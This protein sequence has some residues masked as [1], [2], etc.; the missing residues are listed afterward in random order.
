MTE[1]RR[2]LFRVAGRTL[3]VLGAAGY[4][5]AIVT[6]GYRTVPSLES[7]RH[8]LRPQW[9]TYRDGRKEFQIDHLS[10]WDVVH[11]MEQWTERAVGPLKATDRVAFRYHEPFAFASVVVYRSPKPHS[12]EEWFKLARTLPALA[13]AFGEKDARARPVLLPSKVRALDV[14]A[15]GPM[16]LQTFRFRSFF[17]PR[18][19]TAY[20]ITTGA[21]VRDW[22]RVEST[23]EVMLLSFRTPAVADG[24][25]AS[26]GRAR[27]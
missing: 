2:R 12:E 15:E 20:R 11:P 9:V 23:F 1:A 7:F 13:S 5:G 26:N 10:R 18:G 14:R 4:L 6:N 8:S 16:R 21:D 24:R 27:P 3:V 22:G 19:D 17:I 25:S